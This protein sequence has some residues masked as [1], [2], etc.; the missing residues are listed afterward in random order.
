MNNN[1]VNCLKAGLLASVLV[2]SACG[3]GEN[4]QAQYLEKAQ[5]YLD[6]GNT[7]KARVEVKN[8]LQINPESAQGRYLMAL[9]EEKNRNWRAVYGHLLAVIELDPNHLDA[10]SKL[11]SLYAQSGDTDKA[12]ELLE[13]VLAVSEHIDSMV[14]KSALLNQQGRKQ[15]ALEIAERVVSL[16][17]DSTN[18]ISNLAAIQLNDDPDK[19]LS[20]VDEGL[21]LHGGDAP[22]LSALKIL[23]LSREDRADEV[24]AAYRDLIANNPD[25]IRYLAAMLKYMGGKERL[26]EGDDAIR[27]AIAKAPENVELKLMYADSKMRQGL[28]DEVEQILLGYIAEYPDEFRFKQG[29]SRFYIAAKDNDKAKRVFSDIVDQDG[30]SPQAIDARNKL[31]QFALLEKDGEQVESLLAEIFERDPENAEALIVQARTKM[32]AKETISDAIPDLRAVLKNDPDNEAALMMLAVAQSFEG[33]DELALANLD[34]LLSINSKNFTA[35]MASA[36]I[37]LKEKA[38]GR[39]EPRLRQAHN[40]KPTELEPARLLVNA[41]GQQKK[42]V[43]ALAATQVLKDHEN[44]TVQALGYYSDGLIYGGQQEFDKAVAAFRQSLEIEPRGVESLVALLRIYGSGGKIDEGLD[45]LKQ[46]VDDNPK[47]YHAHMLLGDAYALQKQLDEALA[48]YNEALALAP[49]N[50]KLYIRVSELHIYQKNFEKAEQILDQGLAQVP[51]GVGL[52]FAKARYYS[53]LGQNDKTEQ[54]YEKVLATRPDSLPAINNLTM[55][56][57]NEESPSEANVQRAS[58][59][60]T[61]LQGEDNPAYLDTLGWLEYRKGNYK[62]AISIIDTAIALGGTGSE[63]HYHLGMAYYKN[64][65]PEQALEHLKKAVAAQQVF[66]GVEIAKR[67]LEELQQ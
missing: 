53:L 60:A 55:L 29:L 13:E 25:D 40:L 1:Y 49:K 36:K 63:Y 30:D 5:A 14:L 22:S 35:L 43:E 57:I 61:E 39:A 51:N 17:P 15:E 12:E 3:G 54:I 27:E 34:I 58:Q 28:T 62:Q 48:S 26:A 21:A 50:G 64:K 32:D 23:I 38:W 67:T 6:D 45:Y 2:L 24:I 18:G 4:R 20:I 33:A 41:L 52:L 11:A 56:L 46:H 66:P 16:A 8:A 7:D 31:I 42:W 19:A 10:K 9:I 47:Q 65:Q 59:L 37:L 44:K